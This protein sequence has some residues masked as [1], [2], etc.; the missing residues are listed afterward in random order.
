MQSHITSL[1]LYI[2]YEHESALFLEFTNGIP[3]GGVFAAF[4]FM[5]HFNPCVEVWLQCTRA[6]AIQATVP[7]LGITVSDVGITGFAD[8]LARQVRTSPSVASVH[9]AIATLDSTLDPALAEGGYKQNVGKR[10][11]LV[12]CSGR[13]S[14]KASKEIFR[15]SRRLGASIKRNARY[16]GPTINIDGSNVAEAARLSLQTRA[17]MNMLSNFWRYAPRKIC[18]RVHR[19]AVLSTLLDAQVAFVPSSTNLNETDSLVALQFRRI[20]AGAACNVLDTDGDKV[21]KH[22]RSKVLFH[23]AG[24]SGVRI[25]MRKA[26]LRMWQRVVA[27]PDLHE[28]L[29]ATFF[30]KISDELDRPFDELGR[31]T[32]SCH[33]W[34]LQLLEDFAALADFDSCDFARSVLHNVFSL[35]N[36]S[37]V[38]EA[39]VQCDLNVLVADAL[40]VQIPP[41]GYRPSVESVVEHR[42]FVCETDVD[43]VPC[44]KAFCTFQRL[45]SHISRAHEKTVFWATCVNSV[46]WCLACRRVYASLPTVHAHIRR[47]IRNGKCSGRGTRFDTSQETI[48]LES[49]PVCTHVSFQGWSQDDIRMH[50]LLH[51]PAFLAEKADISSHVVIDEFFDTAA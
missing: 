47:A 4:L 35:F 22:L 51:F 50:L 30:G 16:L 46:R 24:W 32:A 1:T 2:E 44:G 15:S 48:E 10:V 41:P 18:L 5:E 23:R 39:F 14:F 3:P 43:G 42:K 26:R 20:W 40:S 21:Y 13:G 45:R 31:Q 34:G 49:C 38:S 11:A 33:P 28:Q 6:Y 17:R 37:E 25:E 8:D 9:H 19:A 29:L 7:A 36:D 27:R 12:S